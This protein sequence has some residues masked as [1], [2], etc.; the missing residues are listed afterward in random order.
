MSSIY[1]YGASGHGFVVAD[2]AQSC[3][4]EDIILIDDGE[5]EYPSFQEI[6]DNTHIPIALGVGDNHIRAKLFDDVMQSGF[7]LKTLIH[8]SAIISPHSDIGIATVVMPNVV[9][10][11]GSKIGR[12]VILNTSC[13]I[14]HD[15]NIEDFTH[16]SPNVALAG[17]VNI[18]S[19]THMGISSSVIQGLKIGKNSIIGAG[20]VVLND[21]ADNKKVVG[22][23]TREI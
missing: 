12:G 19:F 5:N 11:T 22:T 7:T 10:N 4:Y 13:I 15:N 2:I 6:R 1:I 16:I 20:S 9:I 18:G 3:G 21:I 8:P 23:P 14:E 17:D